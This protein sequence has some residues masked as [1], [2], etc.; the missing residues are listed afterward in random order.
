MQSPVIE[1]KGMGYKETDCEADRNERGG[2]RTLG[3]EKDRTSK[4]SMRDRKGIERHH[5]IWNGM[6]TRKHRHAH[7][8]AHARTHTHTHTHK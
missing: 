1:M 8:R 3:E 6:A 2:M 4:Q 5:D 7:A